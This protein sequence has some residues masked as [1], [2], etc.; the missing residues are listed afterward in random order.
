LIVQIDIFK[1]GEY[2]EGEQVGAVEDADRTIRE[3]GDLERIIIL[4]RNRLA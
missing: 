3:Q 1:L 2:S 4:G